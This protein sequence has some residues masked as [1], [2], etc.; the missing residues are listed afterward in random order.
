[1]VGKILNYGSFNLDQFFTVPHICKSGETLSST[2][3]YVRAG[4]KGANQSM[5]IAKAGGSVFHGGKLGNDAKWSNGRAFIQVSS[6]TGDNCI[7][8][9]PGTNGTYTKED[10]AV[11]MDHF[12]QGDWVLMQ[13]EISQGGAIMRLAAEKGLDIIFNPA[14]LTAG[15]LEEFPFDKV[16]I[17]IVNEHEA[18]DLYRELHGRDAP[19]KKGIELAAELL[20]AF[21]SMKGVILTLGGEGVVAKFQENGQVRDFVV[22][23]RKVRVKDTTGAGDTFVGYFL[24]AFVRASKEDYFA[25]VQ[26]ALEEAN[27]AS[28]IAVERD[29]AMISVPRATEVQER[30]KQN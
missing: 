23:A 25:R 19:Q 28:S 21:N 17:L 10:A 26:L 18:D 5:A 4:G 9:Y 13:N 30:L 14:P 12:G 15:I 8:L 1:M 3:F 11:V 29:G 16:T 24:A 20:A 7:V 22:P 27:V 2:D 6:E